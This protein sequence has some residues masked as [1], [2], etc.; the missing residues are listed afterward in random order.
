MLPSFC[1]AQSLAVLLS[2]SLFHTEGY[3]DLHATLGNRGS[4]FI[5]AIYAI[6][7]KITLFVAYSNAIHHSSMHSFF[8]GMDENKLKAWAVRPGDH[9]ELMYK[10]IRRLEILRII[11]VF[12]NFFVVNLVGVFASRF[13]VQS[14]TIEGETWDW[15]TS[16]YWAVQTTTT[17]GDGDVQ[18]SYSFRW[19]QIFY[20]LFSTYTVA[21][22]LS[23]LAS[24]PAELE[25]VRRDVSW[26][27]RKV[28]HAMLDELQPD[29][30][31]NRIDQYEFA[32]ASLLN[33][34]KIHFEDIKPIMD[35]YRQ[36]A[37]KSGF[38]SLVEAHKMANDEE[39]DMND[40]TLDQDE[41]E[42]GILTLK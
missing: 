9:T 29:D 40:S 23:K 18:M 8:K 38:I 24:L 2:L 42:D 22:S 14:A 16:L 13:F 1:I 41:E 35:K 5:A 6:I 21:N 11:Q 39:Q 27:R 7:S 33:L 10:K 17:I 20:L 25:Q 34:G 37:N 30:N 3:G 12:C 32:I 15:M 4:M 31:D 28:T 19:F 36:L 26:R